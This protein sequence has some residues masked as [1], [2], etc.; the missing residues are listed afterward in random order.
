[1]IHIQ[2]DPDNLPPARKIEFDKWCEVARK[3]SRDLGNDAKLQPRVWGLLK[4]WLLKNVFHGKCA[5]CE[6][7]IE[8]GFV[9]DAE[10]YRPKAAVTELRGGRLVR[11]EKDGT[12]HPG[13]YWLA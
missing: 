6:V 3:A 7:N 4:Q 1:M 13:Y 9:G 2:F 11:V 10:H 12:P 5:Y 8:A